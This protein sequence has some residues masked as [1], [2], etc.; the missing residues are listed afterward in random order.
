[1]VAPGDAG[2][3]G[4]SIQAEALVANAPNVGLVLEQFSRGVGPMSWSGSEAAAVRPYHDFMVRLRQNG[5]PTIQQWANSMALALEE[6]M[7]GGDDDERRREQSF[8]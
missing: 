3:L 4:W 5:H 8:E 2:E 6:R 1:M 7:R